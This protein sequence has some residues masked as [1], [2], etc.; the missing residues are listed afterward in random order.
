MSKKI[1]NYVLVFCIVA[2]ASAATVWYLKKQ[3]TDMPQGMACTEEALECPDGSYVG[4]TGPSCS[5]APCPAAS[6]ETGTLVTGSSLEMPAPA[7]GN[8][9]ETTYRLG[10][11]FPPNIDPSAYVGKKVV[12]QGVFKAGNDYFV[13]SIASAQ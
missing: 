12:V 4:R 3:H 7:G 6:S 10:I 1:L 2:I 8:P 13:D 5:F 9:T 11:T